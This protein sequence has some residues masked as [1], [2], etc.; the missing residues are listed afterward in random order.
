[1]STNWLA[2]RSTVGTDYSNYVVGQLQMN[3]SAAWPQPA[4][5][6]CSSNEITQ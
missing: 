1:M 2:T 6:A 4:P 5:D 3:G